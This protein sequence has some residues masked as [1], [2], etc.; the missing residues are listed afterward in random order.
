MPEM[1]TNREVSAQI[2]VQQLGELL[3]TPPPTPPPVFRA[4]AAHHPSALTTAADSQAEPA[5]MSRVT[6][7]LR[8]FH[9]AEPV[10]L[11]Q[12]PAHAWGSAPGKSCLSDRHRRRLPDPAHVRQAGSEDE[13]SAGTRSRCLAAVVSAPPPPPSC[14]L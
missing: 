4:A 3:I 13:E 14:A 11:T 5:C 6:V 12:I 2:D 7:T 10:P 1:F 8:V 9:S